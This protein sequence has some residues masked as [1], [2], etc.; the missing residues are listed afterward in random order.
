MPIP[1]RHYKPTGSVD[2]RYKDV[3]FDQVKGCFSPA[4]D[5]DRRYWEDKFRG[6]AVTIWTPPI[7]QDFLANGFLYENGRVTYRVTAAPPC[8]SGCRGPFYGICG[9]EGTVCQHL[10]EIGD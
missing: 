5:D 7:P 4:D 6:Q 3:P 10:V 8:P 9:F 1:D 2:T